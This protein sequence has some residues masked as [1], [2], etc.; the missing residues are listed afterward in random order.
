MAGGWTVSK[1]IS[2]ANIITIIGVAAS[3]MLWGGRIERRIDSNVKD[4][5]HL[6]IL[7][8]RNWGLNQKSVDE[9][10]ERLDKIDEKLDQLIKS[11]R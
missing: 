11:S 3:I 9:L 7:Q 8:D 2:P 4:I 5:E 10:K 6:E 1:Q